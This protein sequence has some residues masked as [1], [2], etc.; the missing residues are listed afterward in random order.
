MRNTRRAFSV[1]LAMMMLVSMLSVAASAA[2][3]SL[4]IQTGGEPVTGK[5]EIEEATSIQLSAVMT[6]DALPEG[7]Y[8]VWSTDTPYLASVDENGLLRG[9]DSSKGPIIRVWIDQHIAPIWLVGDPLAQAMYDALDEMDV[10]AIDTDGIMNSMRFILQRIL[11]PYDEDDEDNSV[12]SKLI[13]SLLNTLQNM[14]DTIN[15]KVTATA[16][17]AN[18][19]KIASTTIDILVRKSTKWYAD[20]IPN[21]TYITNK[22]NL[23]ETVEVGYSTQML[24]ITTPLRLHMGVDWNLSLLQGGLFGGGANI[25]ED[26]TITFTKAGKVKVSASP[27]VEGFIKNIQDMIVFAGEAGDFIVNGDLI[28]SIIVDILGVNFV[29]KAV[30]AGIMDGV[31]EALKLNPDSPLNVIAVDTMTFIGNLLLRAVVNDSYTFTVVDQLDVESFDIVGKVRL[32]NGKTSQLGIQNVVPAGAYVDPNEIEWSVSRTDAAYVYPG[33]LLVA[34]YSGPGSRDV[35]ISAKV[36]GVT[37]SVKGNIWGGLNTD[38]PTDIMVTGGP[39]TIDVGEVKQVTYEIYP[40]ALTESNKWIDLGLEMSDGSIKYST[41]NVPVDNGI[42]SVS[43]NKIT[44]LKGGTTT[45][46]VRAQKKNAYGDRVYDTVQVTVQRAVEGFVIDQGAYVS[47]SQTLP[48]NK[49]IQLTATFTPEDATDKTLVWTSNNASMKV[50]ANGK[51]TCK[52]TSGQTALITATT[53]DGK[54]TQSIQVTIAKTLVSGI[55]IGADF[56]L[57]IGASKTLGVTFTPSNPKIKTV[58]WA[59][60]NPAVATVDA[61]GKVTAVGFGTAVITATSLDGGFTDSIVVSVGADKAVLQALLNKIE[62]LVIDGTDITEYYAV[63]DAAMDVNDNPAATQAEVD[64][65]VGALK[66]VLKALGAPSSSGVQLL[67][68]GEDAGDHI[69]VKLSLFKS[70]KKS[71]IQLDYTFD[72]TV[73]NVTWETSDSTGRFS[74]TQDGLVTNGYISSKSANITITVEDMDGNFY[75]DIVRVKF[76]K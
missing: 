33:G 16:Y 32:R 14:L 21:G 31:V 26:G 43:G 47:V 58:A 37:E 45:V 17:D 42:V 70:Y 59:S 65:A 24:G 15:P 50:D 41:N 7:G 20:F 1:L 5:L 71:P 68:N 49:S 9:H 54:C 8:I 62:Q 19:K 55:D 73:K 30:I 2:S 18:G 44:G 39:Y 72:G 46:Y 69:T 23:P 76:H 35:T 11:F 67:Y 29:D 63:V 3:Y 34:R 66:D 40:E 10:D 60:G 56:A 12:T 52:S 74:V 75:S 6:K 51:V 25:V 4:Q 57:T 36:D 64:A 22:A 48:Y 61:Q 38:R 27:D 13:N 28:A 53:P